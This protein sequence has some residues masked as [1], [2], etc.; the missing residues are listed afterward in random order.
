M[1]VVVSW[2]VQARRFVLAGG[3]ATG[4]H[5]G[6]MAVALAAGLPA[7]SATVVGASLG[8]LANYFLQYGY[9]FA[10]R[11]I[12]HARAARRYALVAA[13]GWGL[14]ATAFLALHAGAGMDVAPAQFLTSALVAMTNFLL[15][16]TVVFHE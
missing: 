16:R 6:V 3:L 11:R 10:A 13:A 12:A 8:A 15:Y 7:L 14:N 4:V 5:L 2:R 9:T 1:A